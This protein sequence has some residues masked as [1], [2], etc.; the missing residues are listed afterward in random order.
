MRHEQI[1]GRKLGTMAVE[2]V[3]WRNGANR[4]GICRL[5]QPVLGDKLADRLQIGA[6][7]HQKPVRLEHP[8]KLRQRQ[9][10]F[11][12]IEMLDIMR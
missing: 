11:V 4:G 6:S 10:H 7:Q 12:R 8:K 2:N 9:R 3:Q 1:T 5:S